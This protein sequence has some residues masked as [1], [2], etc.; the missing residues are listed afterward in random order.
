MSWYNPFSWKK[1]SEPEIITEELK[2]FKNKGD[3][4]VSDR[5]LELRSGEGVEDLAIIQ[6]MGFGKESLSSFNSFYN[7]NI[8]I[9]FDNERQRIQH[10]R[11]MADM[12]E[13]G[14]VIEDAVI[15]STQENLE[16]DVISL[17][18]KDK[19]LENNS[20]IV[21]NLQEQFEDLFYNRIDIK[22]VIWDLFRNYY[23]D[24]RYYYEKIIHQ[25]KSKNGIIGIKILPAETMDFIHDPK[26]GRIRAFLQYLT[27]KGKNYNS[28]EEASK[29]SDIIVFYPEQIGYVDY[30]IYGRSRKE[31]IG[32][33]E[34]VKQ[35]YNQLKLL[36]TSVVIYRLVRSPERLVFRI[37]TGNMPKDKAMK[38]VEKIK[39]KFTTKVSYDSTTGKMSNNPEIFSLLENYFLPQSSDGRGSQVDSIG[40]NAAG[41]AELDDIYYFGRKLYRALKYP[42]SRVTASQ[43]RQESNVIFGGTTFG[44]IQ[45]DEVKWSKFLERNQTRICND[46]LKLFLLHLEF[47]GLKKEY[48]LDKSKLA[49]VMTPPNNYKDQLNQQI[50]QARM[51][52]YSSLSNN[53]E[54]SKTFLMK[55]FLK[56]DDEMIKMNS[57]GF[58][59]DKKYLPQDD[60]GF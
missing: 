45:R 41:F 40:G 1:T 16:G 22:N 34:K 37:D 3:D 60:S 26:T 57:E 23:I 50:L 46:L 21:K 48:E 51:N 38:F 8:N 36:E 9:Q 43:E 20:N 52:N 13:I 5:H 17:V 49:I 56:W 4:N 11:Q 6:G 27:E 19:D 28:L 15:E 18:I 53:S 32:Y 30:G 55:E 44:E 39:Q 47:Q 29:D 33:L 35:P 2:S 58:D 31:I 10:Y 7:K 54:F 42:M 14:D 59:D 25:A 12:P 24:G